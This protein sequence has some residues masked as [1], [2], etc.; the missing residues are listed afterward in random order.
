MTTNILE[1]I[2]I[3]MMPIKL[4]N[5]MLCMILF[6]EKFIDDPESASDSTG[7]EN[8]GH[9]RSFGRGPIEEFIYR[10]PR[11]LQIEEANRQHSSKEDVCLG[12]FCLGQYVQGEKEKAHF[13][14]VLLAPRKVL[15]V[16]HTL[17]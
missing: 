4:S 7:I 12:K 14:S 2:Y 8:S 3:Y 10:T 9:H 17:G 5:S 11:E 13:L 16:W 1:N 6:Q 15:S